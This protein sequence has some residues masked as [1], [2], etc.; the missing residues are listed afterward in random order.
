MLDMMVDA[1]VSVIIDESP[2]VLGRQTV[3]TLFCFY[4][5]NRNAKRIILVDI[6]IFR[7]VNSTSLSLLLGQVLQNFNRDW[8]DLLAI[9]TDSA[10]YNSKLVKDLQKSHCPQLTYIKDFAHLIHVAVD[11]ARCSPTM[12]DIHQ[13]VI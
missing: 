6:S 13:V 4:D 9:S 8:D 1:K 2:D 12:N 10:E 7:A 5:K 3:N 11:H